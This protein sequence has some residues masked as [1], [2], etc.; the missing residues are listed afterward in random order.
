MNYVEGIFAPLIRKIGQNIWIG[1]TQEAILAAVP[2]T[3]V[4][5]VATLIS[6]L[7]VLDFHFTDLSMLSNFSLVYLDYF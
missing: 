4:G 6:V 1:A 7:E 2:A 5:S 3:L